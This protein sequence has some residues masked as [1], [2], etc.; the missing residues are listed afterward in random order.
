MSTSPEK[1][2]HEYTTADRI[3]ISP[4]PNPYAEIKISIAEG[5]GLRKNLEGLIYQIVCSFVSPWLIPAQSRHRVV[6]CHFRRMRRPQLLR[7]RRLASRLNGA[8]SFS[9]R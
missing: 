2:L 5:S 1:A 4:P 8:A 6:R 7:E 3:P 9:A